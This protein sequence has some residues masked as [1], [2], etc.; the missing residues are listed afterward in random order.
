[1]I[2]VIIPAR[3]ASATIGA[4]LSSLAG[5][6][7]LIGEVLLIDDSSDDDTVAI[8]SEA[9]R[10]HGLPLT[11]TSVRLGNAGAARNAGLALA[12][13]DQIFFLDADDEVTP[14]GIALLHN[15]LRAKPEAGLAVGASVHRLSRAAKV[16]LP[17]SYGADSR[18]NARRYLANELRSITVGSALVTAQAASG[19]RFPEKVGLDEDTLY[20]AAVLTR[21]S[22]ATIEQPVLVYNLDEARMAQRFVTNPRKVFLDIALQVNALAALG[23]D[24]NTLQGR[25]A[26]IAQRIARHLLRRKR[27]REASAIMRAVR[28]RPQFRSSLKTLQYRVRIWAGRAAQFFRQGKASEDGALAPGPNTD[29]GR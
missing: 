20:W 4:T 3:N 25:K 24:K 18:D 14:G 26:F 17:G 16:K 13:G 10:S 1:M 6:R 7:I 21:A 5:D 8:A 28:A 23:I 11:V 12:R 9:A 2:S 27:Y 19:I 22:V 29:A 15:A